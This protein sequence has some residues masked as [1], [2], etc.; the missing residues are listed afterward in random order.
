MNLMMRMHLIAIGVAIASMALVHVWVGRFIPPASL[1]LYDLIFGGF[2]AWWIGSII[3]KRARKTVN[4]DTADGWYAHTLSVFWVGNAA[5]VITFWISM[6]YASEAMQ[7]LVTMMCL[8]TMTVE[9]IG[10]VRTPTYGRRGL[11]GTLAPLGVPVGLSA[12]YAQSGGAFAIPVIL[13]LITFCSALLVMREILQNSVDAAWRAKRAAEAAG[14]ARA[15]FLASASHDLG[16]P[17]QAARLFFDQ[18]VQSP[19]GPV[20][21]KAIRNVRWA[22]DT[23]S[24]LLEQIL[25]HLRLESGAV[26]ARITRVTLGPLIAEIAE[27]REPAARLANLDIVAL[28]TRHAAHCDPSL[29]E[30]AIGNLIDNAIRH[31]HASRLLIG[32]RRRAGR[33]R[34][35]V[36]DDGVGIP[37]SDLPRLFEDHVQGSNHGDEIRGGFGLGLASTR[38]LVGLMKGATGHDGRWTK[39]SAFWIELP[40]A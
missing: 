27:M 7:L 2:I 30:R 3:W 18:V 5:V 23:T 39:G 29:L 28:P 19:E 37:A 13:W 33:V 24:A 4:D 38:R 21:D 10:T 17:L 25:S 31:A 1:V 15:R 35:W 26:E 20:R 6:P 8:G 36:I 40:L 22:F 9:A 12:W 34:I 11:W 32:A 16:Q 14:D